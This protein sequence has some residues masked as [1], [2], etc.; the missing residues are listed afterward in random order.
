MKNLKIA[1]IGLGF[2]GSFVPIYLDHPYVD[3][4]VLY[5]LDPAISHAFELQYKSEKISTAGSFEQ[6]LSDPSIDA[7]HIMTPIPQHAEQ[8]IQ[9]LKAGKHCACTVP[10]ATSLVDIERINNAIS[11]SG[12]NYMMMETTLYTYQ[13]F[14]AKELLE[15]GNF[16]ELQFVRGSHYQNM[17]GWPAYWM[18]LP[19]MWYG[20]HATAPITMLSGSRIRRVVCFG[21]GTLDEEMKQQYNNP[22]STESA[23]LEYENG[24]KG[25]VT[26]AL[27][28][29]SRPYQ[30]GMFLYGSKRSFEWGFCD[31]D[32]PYLCT[33]AALDA[34][35]R[36]MGSDVEA[37]SLPNYHSLLPDSI[38]RHTVGNR[39]DPQNPQ[40]SLTS[41]TGGGHH[42]SHP[43]LVHEF[44]MSIQERRKPWINEN[45]ASNITAACLCAH[46]SAMKNGTP[47]DVP[48]W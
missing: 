46:Q 14:Y 18:G 44:I 12:K 2:G 19:P 36:G 4:V 9:V 32:K 16:G 29:V 35:W 27:F 22:F 3:H 25:E 31:G 42:G 11:L 40:D 17:T 10:M 21:S 15:H 37:V 20:T 8:S 38:Q 6:I 39:F 28:N 43:H 34:K 33:L 5:D 30:E 26:R 23:L 7:V 24:L 1:L 48:S 47:I 13:Y 41:G 45:F